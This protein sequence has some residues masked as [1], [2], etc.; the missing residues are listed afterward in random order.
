[1]G[2]R[3]N[4]EKIIEKYG[5]AYLEA[6]PGCVEP[7]YDDKPVILG[8]WNH[9]PGKVFDMLERNGYSCEWLDEWSSCGNCG[10]VFRTSPNSYHWQ[11]AYWMTEG[12]ITCLECLDPQE[13]YESLENHPSKCATD[14]I[15][16]KYPIENYGYELVK[17]DYQNGWHEGMNDDPKTILKAAQENKPGKYIFV[18]DEQ[19]Q[20][21]ITFSLYRKMEDSGN[22]IQ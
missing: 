16:N 19:S 5:R 17:D 1:M 4:L 22:G 20:F 11:P 21:Y 3:P 8:D 6:Y 12:D 10:K 9:V 2:R 18:L 13:Y 7:R 15:L 14:T